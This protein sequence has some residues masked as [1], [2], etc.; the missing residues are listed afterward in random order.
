MI[1]KSKIKI[2]IIFA[3]ILTMLTGLFGKSINKAYAAEISSINTAYP[4]DE[5]YFDRFTDS[6]SLLDL[7]SGQQTGTIQDYKKSLYRTGIKSYT[8]DTNCAIFN[9]DGD[10]PIIRIIPRELFER[11][12]TYLHIGREYGFYV[13]TEKLN[14]NANKSVAFVFDIIKYPL[15]NSNYPSQYVIEIRP[16]FQYKYYYL[17]DNNGFDASN[18]ELQ[19]K[20]NDS[21]SSIIVPAPTLYKSIIDKKLTVNFY[22][23]KQYF[24][25]DIS[26]GLGL[27]NEQELNI[28]DRKYNKNDDNGS[29]ITRAD[30]VFS[31]VGN[32]SKLS[33]TIVS[34][35]KFCLGFVDGVGV[36]ISVYDLLK[37]LVQNI[38]CDFRNDI[39][40]GDYYSTQY[41]NSKSEQLQNYSNL[42]KAAVAEVLSEDKNPLLFGLTKD[43]NY[44]RGSFTLGMTD[45]W[46]TRVFDIIKLSV[47]TEATDALGESTITSCTTAERKTENN[48]RTLQTKELP[49]E[50]TKDVYMLP[51]GITEFSFRAD[52]SGNYKML[53]PDAN[54]MTLTADDVPITFSGNAADVYLQKGE[55]SVVIRN[56]LNERVISTLKVEPETL[57]V[58][59]EKH[60]ILLKAGEELVIKVKSLSTIKQLKTNNDEILIKSIYTRAENKW[61]DYGLYG[62]IKPASSLTYPF[63]GGDYYFIL[64]N[65]STTAA[66]CSFDIGDPPILPENEELSVKTNDN[67]TY[68]KFTGDDTGGEYI[69]TAT[70]MSDV[71]VTAIKEESGLLTS[72]GTFYPGLFYK[73]GVSANE[74]VYI[75][76]KNGNANNKIIIKKEVNSYYWDIQE[77]SEKSERI[78]NNSSYY[79]VRGKE[80]TLNLYINDALV[81]N[82]DLS[83]DDQGT[84]FDEKGY[85]FI[86]S[87]D[88]KKV[89]VPRNS[90]IGGNG[91]IVYAGVKQNDISWNVARIKLIPKLEDDFDIVTELFNADVMSFRYYVPHYVTGFEYTIYPLG[92]IFKKDIDY[93]PGV[94]SVPLVDFTEKYN[95]LV[96]EEE[97][98]PQ[99]IRI[100]IERIYYKDAFSRIVSLDRS[101]ICKYTMNSMFADGDGT[102]ESPYGI[103]FSRH[104]KNIAKVNG[105]N[106]ILKENLLFD[107]LEDFFEF[108]KGGVFDGNNYEITINEDIDGYKENIGLFSKNYGTIKNLNMKIYMGI[109]LKSTNWTNFGA[110]AG[111]NEGT[112]ENCYFESYVGESSC[113]IED[114]K[115]LYNVDVFISGGSTIRAGGITGYNKGTIINCKNDSSFYTSGD[116][117]GIAGVS[118]GNI[119]NSESSG[120]IYYSWNTNNRSVGG[121]VGYQSSGKIDACT[122]SGIISY[123]NYKTDSSDIK[124]RMG[125]IIGHK[126]G[127]VT[128]CVEAGNV[129]TGTLYKKKNILG[130]VIYDQREY[131]GNRAFGRED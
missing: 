85:G 88:D 109:T 108:A 44:V 126:K 2:C 9:V 77:K 120:R 3:I 66:T 130:K 30:V 33:S 26:F 80:Y 93:T 115:R 21:L 16:L 31:G 79:V 127:T 36:I 122:N 123:E 55:H 48:V 81:S 47:V 116:T 76:I 113:R 51:K 86:F 23:T 101:I 20:T 38:A 97:E 117:G 52:Y 8:T 17:T 74:T 12:G 43:D 102:A 45:D 29:F 15:N 124:P 53:I 13:N 64:K 39:E 19:Y 70:D 114:G 58:D 112:I 104:F 27:A 24:L 18:T 83:V 106:Y 129:D 57:T 60:T 37:E 82:I 121:I 59:T 125:Q 72:I 98:K 110:F 111:I 14:E 91:V 107:K 50:N 5:E 89:T 128:N 63:K 71:S 118:E 73:L 69:F 68:V 87:K 78:S 84:A 6:D 4:Y 25:K 92:G 94:I 96:K 28:G 11:R 34:T 62:E 105:K 49:L 22:E 40:N 54:K 67:Y 56:K 95:N 99:Q 35:V 61:K 100:D 41:Y 10:D 65:I 119:Y 75:G 1:N 32:Q 90:P 131:A 7:Q 103:R 42:N 46:Y